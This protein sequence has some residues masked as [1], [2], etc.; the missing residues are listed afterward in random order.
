[1]HCIF[2]KRDSTGSG[3]VE[4][5]V[6]ESLGNTEHVLPPGVVCDECNN[7]L[8]RAVEKPVLESEY[9]TQARFVNQVPSK[10]GA[11]P[12]IRALH[13]ESAALVEIVSRRHENAIYPLRQEDNLRFVN[14]ITTAPHGRLVL[15]VSALSEKDRYPM[16][17]FL[18]KIAIEALAQRLLEVPEALDD[19]ADC[20]ELDPLRAYVR[21]GSTTLIWPFHRRE[22]YPETALFSENGYGQFQV[23][24][25][26]T[27]LY[28]ALPSSNEMYSVI[29]L[30]GV[31]YAL[32]LDAPNTVGYR[33]W[34]SVNTGKSPLYP[35]AGP[36]P[37]E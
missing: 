17:R 5:I 32:N 27:F 7:Y 34:L 11:L 14:R 26:W 18:G 2:C 16:S 4:H 25:E 36:L 28:P 6:P 13:V 15:P 10:R 23:L 33:E 29:A 9:F 3:A 31:E 19:L 20:A 22:I 35:H 8:G 24:H 30:F 37:A 12:T 1:M 21:R